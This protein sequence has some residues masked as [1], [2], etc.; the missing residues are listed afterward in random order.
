MA[1]RLALSTSPY[2]LQHAD[3]PVDWF[4][5][6]DEAFA[7]ARRRQV[8]ILLSVGYSACHWC[9][10]MA[11][12]SFEDPVT[13]NEMNTRFVNVKV[14]REERPDVDATYM[15]A[16]QTMTG[17]GGWPMTVFL[18]PDLEPFF[19]GT[20]FPRDDRAG[21]PSFRRVMGSLSEAWEQRRADVIEQAGRITNAI[22]VPLTPGTELPSPEAVANAYRALAASFEPVHG[23]F[24]G[25]PKFPQSPSLEF[26]L[27]TWQE[28]WAPEGGPMLRKTLQAMADGG[29]HDHLAG[30][31]ARY[32]VDDRWL[33]PHF[34]KMLYDNA[35]L[36]RVYMWAGIEFA[37]HRFLEVAR[38]TLDYLLTDLRHPDGGFY[39]AEDADSEGVEGKFY[40][41][42]LDEFLEVAADDGLLGTRHFGVTR[43]GNFDGH[44]ILHP[45]ISAGQAAAELGIDTDDARHR[46]T[47]LRRRLLERRQTRVRPGLDDK[48]IAAWN[49]LAI[50]ALAEAGAALDEPRYLEAA[51]RAAR[52]VLDHMG[53][54]DGGLVR[55]WAKGQPSRVAGFLDDYAAMGTALLSLY[56]ATGDVEWF[57][58]AHSLLGQLANRF[59]DEAGG[60]FTA[61]ATGELPKRPKDIFD[62]PT[63]SGNALAAEALLTLS[64]Y[65][66]EEG[67][68]RQA[69]ETLRGLGVILERY[70]TGAAYALGVLHNIHQGTHELAVV[71]EK[72]A[73]LAKVYWR[74][75]RPHVA[76]AVSTVDET[77]V[78]LLVDRFVDGATRAYLCS[79]FTCLAPVSTVAELVAS[80][81]RV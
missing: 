62:N 14:D 37:E 36:A 47:E 66:G 32:S 49:G 67:T 34:E 44:N 75:L 16:V 25:A 57:E 2:L 76:L 42:S 59:G 46:M 28:P 18:T 51:T 50:R 33:V 19:A 38:S 54:A 30:G 20:Y 63:P 29:I 21:M 64:L 7:E 77:R 11:H 81:A 55:T 58:A 78:P 35:L 26:L 6:G 13:A 23:G 43:A 72:S 22:S 69:I 10:V 74:R 56:A 48:V 8:P 53:T 41:W 61:E 70:P 12:E 65:T 4:E 9:H 15:E 1:N 39:S 60:F 17:Q 24:G 52:F 27:R 71:G 45:V 80:L 68:R 5:W 40:V 79:G 73:E 3:N 31:F